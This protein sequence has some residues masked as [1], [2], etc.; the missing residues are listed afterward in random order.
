[1]R[2]HLS[3]QD[4]KSLH[5]VK[6]ATDDIVHT[7]PSGLWY[8][9]DDS[10]KEY[11]MRDHDKSVPKHS[12]TIHLRRGVLTRRLAETKQ[13]K[14]LQILTIKELYAFHEKYSYSPRGFSRSDF[15]RM[16][17]GVFGT[18]HHYMDWGRVMDDFAGIEIYVDPEKRRLRYEIPMAD[19]WWFDTFDIPSGC[20]WKTR[21]IRLRDVL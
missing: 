3:S 17:K 19:F 21:V 1:M 14:V 11:V 2:I 7:K 5:S 8:A 15:Y 6:L 20:I 9:F 10:W 4:L 13:D 16:L 12:Y 18:R